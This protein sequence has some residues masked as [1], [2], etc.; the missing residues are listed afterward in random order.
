MAGYKVVWQ[1]EIYQANWWSQGTAP[2]STAADSTT[3]DPWL[4]IGPVP[5]GSQ[6]YQ[7]ELLASADQAAWSPTTVY[8]QG[9]RVSFRGLPYQARWYTKGDQP[10]DAAPRQPEL[11]LGAAVHS[12][13][14]AE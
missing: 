6:T 2:G 9:Q 13:R 14:R 3:S 12:A 10:L 7:P 1:G 4:L 11:P 5:S 8:H